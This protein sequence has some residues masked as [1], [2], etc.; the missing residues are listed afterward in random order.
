MAKSRIDRVP[1][2]V[3]PVRKTEKVSELVAREILH[4]IARRKLPPGSKLP[5]EAELVAKYQVARVS[6]R[7]ALR[8]LEVQGL[9]RLKAG[10]GGGP[11]VGEV[12]S[13]DFARMATMYYHLSGATIGELFEARLSLETEMAAYAARTRDPA[14]I[15]AL[16]ENL[17]NAQQI[18]ADDADS[19][20]SSAARS[21]H[22]IIIELSGNRILSLLSRSIKDIYV[23][24]V[25]NI[26]YPPD[27]RREIQEAHEGIADA[28]LS[29]DDLKAANLMRAHM[30][31]YLQ[32]SVLAN[33]PGLL[34]EVIDWR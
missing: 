26:Q 7:E 23:E 19:T 18:D 11:L 33:I 9:V 32:R 22:D 2:A 1:D 28:I 25:R 6:L 15:E 31:S 13:I 8:I 34:D 27:V 14:M 20:H 21:F 29:G 24:R 4:D 17:A 12:R 10:A 16:K 5:P 3:A 30:Q